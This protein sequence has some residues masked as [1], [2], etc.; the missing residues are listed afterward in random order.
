L[1]LILSTSKFTLKLQ[2]SKIET[3]WRPSRGSEE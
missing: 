2:N 3:H 1:K